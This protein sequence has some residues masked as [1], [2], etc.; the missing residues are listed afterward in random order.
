MAQEFDPIE[1]VRKHP[2][3]AAGVVFVLAGIGLAT[4]LMNQRTGPRRYELIKE[5]LDPRGWVDPDGLKGRFSDLA[6]SVR[7]RVDGLGN[8]AS[9]LGERAQGRVN[10]LTEDA[11]GL[12]RGFGKKSSRMHGYKK[13]ARRYAE[14]AGDFARDHAREGGAI[15]AV[16]FV[17]AALGAIA[18]ENQKKGGG[19]FE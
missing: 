4:L 15:L 18:L 9:S 11:M 7:D 13:Q 10:R 16:A 3:M 14:D 5:R 6:H 12:G 17:A 8:R 19:L 1:E 2:G